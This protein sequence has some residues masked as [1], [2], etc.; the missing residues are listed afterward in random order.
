M[1]KVP[2]YTV[3]TIVFSIMSHPNRFI[4]VELFSKEY[5]VSDSKRHRWC[6]LKADLLRVIVQR[7]P[8]SRIAILAL[9]EKLENTSIFGVC[10]QKK[11]EHCDLSGKFKTYGR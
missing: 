7:Y 8:K 11:V 1:K 6:G 10:R 4:R 9:C 3:T 2:K 5:S